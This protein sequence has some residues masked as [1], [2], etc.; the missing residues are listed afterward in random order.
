MSK[1]S[2]EEEKQLRIS[3]NVHPVPTN[4]KLVSANI[5]I[6]AYVSVVVLLIVG[7]VGTAKTMGWYGTSGKI[8]SDG[9]AIVLSVNSTG[10]DLKGWMTLDS[11]LKAYSITKQEFQTQFAITD[12]L[13]ATTTLGE[14]GEITAEAVGVETLR[15]WVDAGHTLENPDVNKTNTTPSS[16]A[17]QP[18]GNPTGI[19]SVTDENGDF[20][21]KGRTT[22]Q[23]VLDETKVSKAEFYK[24]FKLPATL[25]TSIG[26]SAI[27]ESVPDFEVSLVQD[28][29]DARN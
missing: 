19:P 29:F 5:P 28:W 9:K 7:L 18:S 8:S 17:G 16:T 4:K 15:E 13:S 12:Q 14:L 25:S 23:E 11:F 10:A 6:I 26:L 22:I 24:E 21:I 1:I 3:P 27:K 20:L 2:K